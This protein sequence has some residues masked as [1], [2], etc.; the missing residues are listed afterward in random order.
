M[1]FFSLPAF[2][3]F[4][5]TV[6]FSVE[7]GEELPD[8]SKAFPDETLLT[9]GN[10]EEGVMAYLYGSDLCFRELKKKFVGFIGGSWKEIEIDEDTEAQINRAIENQNMP[11]SG[12]AV[13]TN[14]SFPGVEIT[15]TQVDRA[16]LENSS[17]VTILVD[18][19]NEAE[20]GSGRD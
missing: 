12:Y 17:L 9:Q 18:E 1:K 5:A 3:L 16:I 10:A 8:F 6:T 13:F 2:Y 11:F 7:T 20:S 19:R 15:L 4:T 14:N